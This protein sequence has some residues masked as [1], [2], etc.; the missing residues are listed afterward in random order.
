MSENYKKK[1]KKFKQS[2]GLDWTGYRAKL[3]SEAQS[4]WTMDSGSRMEVI[5]S[6]GWEWVEGRSK[7]A[8]TV[9][10]DDGRKI[11]AF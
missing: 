2:V 3:I 5:D 11:M 6:V 7:E 10:H 8:I 1:T 9:V 4:N